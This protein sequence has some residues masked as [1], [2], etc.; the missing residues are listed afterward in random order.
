M[1]DFI[2]ISRSAYPRV[3]DRFDE[4]FYG[5]PMEAG[6]P[7]C[8]VHVHNKGGVCHSPSNYAGEDSDE[9]EEEEEE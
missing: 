7:N 3:R 6:F 9:E 1:P 5:D 4:D 8:L 2:V